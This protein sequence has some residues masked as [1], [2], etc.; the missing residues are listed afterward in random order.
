MKTVFIIPALNEEQSIGRVLDEI[1]RA[2]DAAV[3]VA[4]N[5]SSD[6]T[7]QIAAA[8][9]AQVV[10]EPQRGYGNAC[11][12]ALSHL[13]PQT[14]VVVFMDAD[15][16]DVPS[17]APALIDP[18][19]SGGADL[20]LGSRVLGKSEP[21]ALEAHQRGGN[22]VATFLVSLLYGHRYT[23]LGPFRAI[24]AESL[25]SLGMRDPN[26]G[27]TVEM[28]IRALQK[29]LRVLEVPV[30]YRRRQGGTSKVSGN[31]MGSIKA[32]AKILWTVARLKFG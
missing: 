30:S 20:V 2:L 9:G 32:G 4:D 21:G 27:W 25:A 10:R 17:E 13:P 18:I 11:L 23:D 3:I 15:G 12:K 5:G 1:P 29:G 31:L 7:G 8:H 28:Q 24:R 26:Y 19:A 14:G 16:S 6:R 22:A